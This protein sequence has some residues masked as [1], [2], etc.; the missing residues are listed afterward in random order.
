MMKTKTLVVAGGGVVGLSVAR[1]A[2]RAGLQVMLLEKNSRVGMET[3]ARNSE[4]VHAGIYYAHESWKARLCVRGREQL[5]AFCEAYGVPFRKCGKLV[6]ASSDE[7]VPRLASIAARARANGVSDLR[8]LSA[9]DAAAIEPHVQ[10]HQA[11]Y[12]PSTGIVDSHAFMLAVQGDAEAHGAVVALASTVDSGVYD[13]TRRTFVV[14]ATQGGE[15]HD[16][17]CD[18]F[19]NATGIFAPLLLDKFVRKSQREAGHCVVDREAGSIH[20]A[21]LPTLPERFAKGTY[22]KLR[23]SV[24]PFR[25]LVYPIPEPGGLGVHSTVDMHGNVRFGPDVEWVHEI[26]YVPDS[27]KAEVFADR[28]RSYW[29]Q[30]AASDLVADYCGIRPKITVRGAVYED[31]YFADASTH[32]IPGLVHLCGFESPGLTSSLAIADEV[33]KLLE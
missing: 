7:Q 18:Y 13:D 26:D 14:R 2:A 11:L 15:Q 19:V 31:F 28:I 5:Y 6:V 29:P 8:W 16:L 9:R 10:C 33:L 17:E 23:E 12:S 4:V 21:D 24:Q 30:V 20:S 1:A 25:G 32:G 3:S 27:S 22:F